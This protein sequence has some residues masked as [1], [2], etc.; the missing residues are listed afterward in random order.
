MSKLAGCAAD[1]QPADDLAGGPAGVVGP[2]VPGDQALAEVHRVGD[3]VPRGRGDVGQPL[4]VGV[5][6]VADGVDEVP[7]AFVEP[8][9]RVPGA[10]AEVGEEAAD[11]VEPV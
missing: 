3:V 7:H 8:L 5:A 1:E 9:E 6:W 4:V 10:F 2:V 11:V